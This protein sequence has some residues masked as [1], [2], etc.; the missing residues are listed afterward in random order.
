MGQPED[1]ASAVSF[2]ARDDAGFVTGQTLY[3]SGGLA[4]A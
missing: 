2:F 4:H 1:I 3:V